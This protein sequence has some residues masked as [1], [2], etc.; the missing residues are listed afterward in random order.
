MDGF[1]CERCRKTTPGPGSC[2]HCGFREVLDATAPDTALW[3]E[4]NDAMHPSVGSR[5]TEALREH[6]VVLAGAVLF[7]LPILLLA[8]APWPLHG[9]AFW[10]IL[11]VPFSYVAL[12]AMLGPLAA[13]ARRGAPRV[14]EASEPEA[15]ATPRRVVPQR[16]R[17]PEG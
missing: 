11:F 10:S 5:L 7:A 16:T 1:I 8:V 4:V 14:A 17:V 13:L 12:F 3:L 2:P 6:A 15:P 9:S